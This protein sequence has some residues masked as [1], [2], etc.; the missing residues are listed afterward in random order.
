MSFEEQFIASLQCMDEIILYLFDLIEIV[1]S[2]NLVHDYWM[3]FRINIGIDGRLNKVRSLNSDH[4]Y[5]T[6]GIDPLFD[7]HLK[8]KDTYQC[9]VMSSVRSLLDW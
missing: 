2:I 7:T 3:A 8:V 4:K 9:P 5:N 1:L 6:T